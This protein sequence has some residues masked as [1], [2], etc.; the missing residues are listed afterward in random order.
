MSNDTPSAHALP[1]VAEPRKALQTV[2]LG[3]LDFSA[4]PSRE[5]TR[6][7]RPFRL[8]DTFLSWALL[9]CVLNGWIS[10]L[11]L[12]RRITCLGLP[13]FLPVQVCDQAIYNRLG[14][15][16]LALMQTLC[17][18]I[19]QWIF[20]DCAPFEDRTL[21]PFASEVI[22]LDESILDPRKRWIA[23][24]RGVPT[25]AKALLAGR[26]SCLFDLRRQCWRRIDFFPNAVANCQ[27]NAK[28]MLSGLP[29]K[30]LLLFDLGYYNFEWFDD[31]T[32]SGFFWVS[33][34]RSNSSWKHMHWL[35]QRDGYSEALVFL[36]AHPRDQSGYVVRV[37][38]IRYRGKWYVWAT[39]VLSPFDLPGA[40]VARL[41][42]RR[43]DIELAFCVLK[44]DL[45]LNLLW[46]AKDQVI[47]AQIWALVSLAQLLHHL[48]IQV[49]QEAGVPIF[50]VSLELL[51]RH[52][53]DFFQASQ[54]YGKDLLTCI[55]EAGPALGIIRPSTRTFI[56]APIIG[57]QDICFPP[58]D[59]I[60][61]RPGRYTH[62]TGPS[63]RGGTKRK[64]KES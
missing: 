14:Q 30:T 8:S 40:D 33:R 9:W 64:K 20:E 36:G 57:W 24:L 7:G 25:G 31:L 21:A 41:Y 48:Q 60:W 63:K 34:L 47:G 35:I 32:R 2:L 44:K 22:A 1:S 4:Q 18:Q 54:M 15:N 45:Q 46:S 61:I 28:N 6:R 37:I 49:A 56:Q 59:M 19:S 23:D 62:H 17:A 16:G 10:Q 12:W 51:L 29:A 27:L 58:P 5:L 26:L 42:A 53:G 50:D 52:L 11:D 43:W 38:R 39:N 55:V 3:L 13:G